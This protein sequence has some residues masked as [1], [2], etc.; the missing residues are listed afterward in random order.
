[1]NAGSRAAPRGFRVPRCEGCG[2]SREL[3]VCALWSPLDT[4]ISISVVMPGSEAR[5][6]SNSARLLGLWLKGSQSL[7]KGA[8][9]ISEPLSLLARPDTALLFPAGV[10]GEPLP[11]GIRHLIVPDGTWSQARRLERRWFARHALPRVALS[12]DWPSVYALRRGP[13]GLCTFEAIA[14]AIGLMSD[15]VLAQTLLERFREWVLRAEGLKAGGTAPR[16]GAASENGRPYA[17]PAALRLSALVPR[18]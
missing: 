11:T 12:R 2:L 3:C 14:V 16:R 17:H 7:V 13:P 8:D 1:M 10:G 6:A 15:V 4:E 5:S 9:G 18:V